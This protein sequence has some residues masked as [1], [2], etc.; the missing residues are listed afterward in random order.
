MPMLRIGNRLVGDGAPTY[1]IADIS[2]NHDGSLERAK[3]L[4]NLTAER[5]ADAAK[6]QNFRA[7]KI[8]SERGFASME[9]QRSHQATWSKP[10]YQVYVEAS[11][12]WEW[13]AELKAE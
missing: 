1:F 7:P 12:P 4:I 9:T 8:V 10:V 6:F 3:T 13:T 5:G 11:L 2:A